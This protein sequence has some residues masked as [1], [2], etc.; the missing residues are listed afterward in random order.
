VGVAKSQRWC[1]E[2]VTVNPVIVL[3]P[4]L[5]SDFSASLE[6][7]KKLLDRSV[8][9]LPRLGFSLVDVRDVAKLHLLAMTAPEATGQRFIASSEFYWMKD[10]AKILKQ[11]LGD[12][13]RN[14]SSISIP[15][16]LVRIVAMFDPV[17]RGRLFDLGKRRLV[18]SDKA[19]RILGWTTRPTQETILDTAMS[20]LAQGLV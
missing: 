17:L 5:G 15:D 13:A 3:G 20:L 12:K 6:V 14:A 1:L 8:P 10:I 4:A 18:S 9:A 16:F 19:R 2:L 7:I 11:E